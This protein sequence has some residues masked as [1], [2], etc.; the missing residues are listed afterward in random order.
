MSAPVLLAVEADP[1][2]LGDVERELRERY[3]SNYRVVCAS[4]AEEALARL[5]QL[6]EAREEVALVL[7]SQWHPETTAGDLLERVRQLH[8]H[9]KRGLLIPWGA[10]SE[11]QTAEAIFDLM[12][13]G[14]ID[15][16]VL[17]PAASPDELFH[18]T[19][20]SFLLEWTKARHHR[21]A[22]RPHRR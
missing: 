3:A 16:Y 5:T 9:A 13:M 2:A 12:A 10:W 4:S 11:Q 1:A 17:R 21:A 7:A 19:I 22:H 20:S 18:Q 8:P 6:A 14:R 15:Y